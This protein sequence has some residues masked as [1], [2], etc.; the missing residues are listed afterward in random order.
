MIDRAL[1]AQCHTFISGH[2]PK[3]V[4][5]QLQAL[6]ESAHAALPPDRYGEGGATRLLEER[7]GEL[8]AR[9]A[10][11]FVAKGTIAQMAALRVW[12]DQSGRPTAAVHQLS[13]FNQDE[14]GAIE[15]L[16][17]ITLLRC[18]D[19]SG[20]FTVEQ[21]E[22]LGELPGVVSVELPLRNSGYKLTP[23]ED[24]VAISEWCRDNHVPF[25][26]DGA[27]AWGAAVTYGKSLAEIAALCDSIYLSFYKE[28]GGLYGCVLC[29]DGE[30]VAGADT[31]IARHGGIPFRQYPAAISALDGLEKH[32]PRL[33]DY[34]ARARE[35]AAAIND[36]DGAFTIPAVPHT[37]GF[38]I[39]IACDPETAEAALRQLTEE[40]GIWIGPG[41]YS[42]AREDQC[43][44][45]VEIGTAAM[46]LE[47]A[48]WAAHIER[49]IEL[50]RAAA[51]TKAAE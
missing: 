27:R 24:L 18:G 31:W 12:C 38:Q 33:K 2:A 46:R 44:F 6:S 15:R 1:M 43:C 36:V 4:S 50:T 37:S 16:H 3:S 29:G 34:A 40:S 20:P 13:H 32:L 8:V 10:A 35:M 9:D 41:F 11:R 49:L 19:L 47:A 26:I 30:F 51:S 28:L 45:D 25:H 7:V 42:M 23:W 22:E 39:G 17:G 21:L 48:T 5:E 14:M